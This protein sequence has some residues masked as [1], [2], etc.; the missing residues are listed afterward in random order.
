MAARG[1]AKKRAQKAP[2]SRAISLHLG[3]SLIMAKAKNNSTSN[4]LPAVG[5]VEVTQAQADAFDLDP[6]LVNLMWD[7]PFFSRVLR[8]VTKVRTEEVPTAG[9]LACIT[10]CNF[11]TAMLARTRGQPLAAPC[12][13]CAHGCR[14]ST[15]TPA[16]ASC[17]RCSASRSSMPSASTRAAI[18]A[19][20]S[21]H[22][23]NIAARSSA[24]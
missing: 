11:P 2:P 9:V 13:M 18:R 7:E 8:S 12:S 19:K 3:Y 16:I 1:K 14:T 22:A 20:R 6:H 5:A 10:P 17:R 21:W 23:R 4:D 15:R 24:G